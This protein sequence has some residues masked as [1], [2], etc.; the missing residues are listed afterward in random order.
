MIFQCPRPEDPKHFPLELSEIVIANWKREGVSKDTLEH[1]VLWGEHLMASEDVEKK[2]KNEPGFGDYHMFIGELAGSIADR[3]GT[4][5]I[6]F[7]LSYLWAPFN[8][9]MWQPNH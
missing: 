2:L 6:P 7:S 9:T 8:L 5:A 3:Q 4:L 1:I